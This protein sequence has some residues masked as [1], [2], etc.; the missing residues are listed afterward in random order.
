MAVG[1]N[2]PGC[3]STTAAPAISAL[4]RD[5]PLF[6]GARMDE[7]YEIETLTQGSGAFAVVHKA[8]DRQTGAVR[9]LKVVPK[10]AGR[11][12]AFRNEVENHIQLDHPNIVKVFETL[13]DSNN[14]YLAME[15]CSGGELFDLIKEHSHFSESDAACLMYQIMSTVTYCH[16]KCIAHR[17]IKPENF[18]LKKQPSLGQFPDEGLKLI[19]FDAS[20]RFT[21]GRPNGMRSICGTAYY[22]APE[23][24]TGRGY[25][26]LCDVWSCGVILYILLCGSPP[27]SGSSDEET[28]KQVRYGAINFDLDDFRKVSDEVKELIKRM[29]TRNVSK[30]PSAEECLRSPWVMKQRI[31]RLG[32]RGRMARGHINK[33]L[34]LLGA[35]AA[36]SDALLA[37]FDSTSQVDI[38]G[39]LNF[40]YDQSEPSNAQSSSQSVAQGS[41]QDSSVPSKSRACDGRETINNAAPD[42][43][44]GLWELACNDTPREPCY[45][46]MEAAYPNNGSFQLQ[47]EDKIDSSFVQSQDFPPLREGPS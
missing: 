47:Q 43:Q 19:D 20:K 25:N 6:S 9:A 18:M 22:V 38:D 36:E 5:F 42:V 1:R 31:R 26:E 24:L 30:R 8:R 41:S 45:G 10:E 21:P 44:H 40:L 33:V 34:E 15:F 3:G 4:P 12:V 35:N 32:L 16:S 11:G 28:C 7:R 14:L 46:E 23:V 39:L 29:C 27:F 37:P 17:D 13:E 2:L